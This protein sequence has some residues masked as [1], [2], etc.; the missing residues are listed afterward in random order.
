VSTSCS[1]KFGQ[2]VAHLHYFGCDK[3]SGKVVVYIDMFAKLMKFWVIGQ[4]NRALIVHRNL[5]KATLGYTDF[6][7]EFSEPNC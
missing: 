7:Q 5:G 3:L 6:T 1:L 2:N 4:S